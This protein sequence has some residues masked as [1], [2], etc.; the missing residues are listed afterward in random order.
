MKTIDLIGYKRTDLGKKTSKKLRKEALVPC[1]MYGKGENLHFSVPMA[2][3]KDLVY[4]PRVYVVNMDIEGEEHNCILQDVQFHPVSEI[5]LHADFL[6]LDDEK[7]VKIE[8]PIKFVG[9]APGMLKGGKLSPKLRKIKIKAL[10]KDLPDFIEVSIDGLDLGKSI[11]IKDL[12]IDE[13]EILNNPMVTIATIAVPRALR[14]AQRA[15]EEG[16]A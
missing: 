8:V 6:E 16:E 5:I 2:L 7:P 9:A 13:F 14:S 12:S 10:P 4:T 15:A 11:K 3:F 1:V